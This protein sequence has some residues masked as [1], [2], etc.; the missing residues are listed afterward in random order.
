MKNEV[1]AHRSGT[2]PR[3]LHHESSPPDHADSTSQPRA[4]TGTRHECRHKPRSQDSSPLA[5]HALHNSQGNVG[6][7]HAWYQ[8]GVMTVSHEYHQSIDPGMSRRRAPRS[9]QSSLGVAALSTASPF[10]REAAP[11]PLALNTLLID[12]S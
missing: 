8:A 11:F 1:A 2:V 10:Q 7:Y 6:G 5:R 9:P 3:C 12:S 4:L